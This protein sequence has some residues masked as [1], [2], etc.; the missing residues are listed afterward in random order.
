MCEAIRGQGRAVGSLTPWVCV[1]ILSVQSLY[2]IVSNAQSI[3]LKFFMCML[4][5][6]LNALQ[7]ILFDYVCTPERFILVQ[8]LCFFSLK[9]MSNRN[10]LVVYNKIVIAF[11]HLSPALSI[12]F[13][14]SC[15]VFR[16]LLFCF[17]FS[18]VK[19]RNGPVRCWQILENSAPNAKLKGNIQSCGII[20]SD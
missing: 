8:S 14:L 3:L 4:H 11:S 12:V 1:H 20:P 16:G 7:S 9:V 5:A 19:L 6:Q 10:V 13:L 15:I 18:T 2:Y 17:F